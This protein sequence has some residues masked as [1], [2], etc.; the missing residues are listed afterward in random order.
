MPNE[1]VPNDQSFTWC[2]TNNETGRDQC[3][4]LA[5][6]FSKVDCATKYKL[7]EGLQEV[8]FEEALVLHAALTA[9]N[10]KEVVKLEIDMEEGEGEQFELTQ[11][12]LF[13][14]KGEVESGLQVSRHMSHSI[15]CKLTW[16]GIFRS[17]PSEEAS[18]PYGA[19]STRSSAV[20][21]QVVQRCFQQV[22]DHLPQSRTAIPCADHQ[23]GTGRR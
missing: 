5:F 2:M 6:D 22:S 19:I 1:Y 14:D 13:N 23:E 20:A 12:A 15:T 8:T 9:D 3:T 11:T 10:N 4:V 17:R 21:P 18:G 7:L 16:T